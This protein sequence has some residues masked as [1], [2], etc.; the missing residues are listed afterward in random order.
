MKFYIFIILNANE[1]S[2]SSEKINHSLLPKISL[3]EVVL[4]YIQIHLIITLRNVSHFIPLANSHLYFST[5]YSSFSEAFKPT[6][7]LF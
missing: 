4:F 6:V 5:V 1:K 2:S 7:S 3:F